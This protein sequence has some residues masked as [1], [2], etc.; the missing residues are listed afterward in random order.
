MIES[1][2]DLDD[3]AAAIGSSPKLDP[4]DQQRALSL[5]RVWAESRPGRWVPVAG[6]G[7]I[8]SV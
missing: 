2:H 1:R 7:D 6:R 3:L 8:S 5:Y 4:N